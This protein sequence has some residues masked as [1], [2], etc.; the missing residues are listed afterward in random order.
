MS[1]PLTHADRGNRS[2]TRC[3]YNA[4]STTRFSVK[5]TCPTCA[6]SLAR[7]ARE[8]A[9]LEAAHTNGHPDASR[10]SRIDFLRAELAKAA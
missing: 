3:G 10:S 2:S 8:L 5:P 1:K 6:G 4:S 7:I 9:D